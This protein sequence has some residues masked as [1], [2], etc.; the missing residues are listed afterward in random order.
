MVSP[1]VCAVSLCKIRK[2]Y[3]FT[4]SIK[5]VLH[6]KNISILPSKSPGNRSKR[7]VPPEFEKPVSTKCKKRTLDQSSLNAS[8][9]QCKQK[10]KVLLDRILGEFL[11]VHKE[12][13]ESVKEEVVDPIKRVEALTKLSQALD[14]TIN[15]LVKAAPQTPHLTIAQS[16]LKHQVTFVETNFPHHAEVLLI[17]L[18][19]FGEEL[20]QV[21]NE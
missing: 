14:K 9:W 21:F 7:K 3:L 20:I 10:R 8:A 5:M 13:M 4:R 1:F 11:V 19:P 18:E 15:A 16:V 12:A 17:I 2:I 6:D